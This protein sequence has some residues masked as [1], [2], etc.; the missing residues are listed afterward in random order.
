MY[1][2]YMQ[3]FLNYPINGYQNTY[4]DIQ[5]NYIYPRYNYT[6]GYLNNNYANRGALTEEIEAL[7]PEIYKVVY[8][9]VKKAVENNKRTLTRDVIEDLVEQIYSNIENKEIELNRSL[10]SNNITDD[11]KGE[12]ENRQ[13]NRNSGLMD[14]I[15]ILILR[16]LIGRP[17]CG[18]PNC[19]P[20]PPRPPRPPYPRPPYNSQL[21]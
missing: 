8:P 2:D 21:F 12:I 19:R 20:Q 9:M 15:K 7:Y 5:E 16:E 4:D 14:I 18:G 6:M 11:K 17:G 3:N 13:I 1:E 10:N